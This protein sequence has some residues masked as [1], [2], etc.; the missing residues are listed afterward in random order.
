MAEMGS[1]RP[2]FSAEV[3]IKTGASS[4]SYLFNKEIDYF[5]SS[6][7]TSLVVDMLGDG[8]SVQIFVTQGVNPHRISQIYWSGATPDIVGF[9]GQ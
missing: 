2:G 3:A 6:Q 8:T 9:F 4:V 7:T 5:T 1:M